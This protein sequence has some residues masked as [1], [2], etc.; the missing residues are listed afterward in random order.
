MADYGV[1]FAEQRVARSRDEALGAAAGLGYPVV[2]KSDAPGLEHKADVGGVRLGL[3]DAHAV[4]AAYDD[5]AARL[6][7]RVALQSLEPGPVELALG[8]VRDPL[9]GP[10]VLLA[11]GGTLVEVVS[12]R[13][14]ALP[15]LSRD[16]A[17]ALV[18]GFD[19]VS[20]LLSGVRGNP[21][22][23]R[24]AV[25]DALVAVGQLAAELGGAIDA[26]DVNPLICG[27]DGAV[28]VDA[29]VQPSA[30]KI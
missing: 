9:L 4:A 21:P 5:M 25:V 20:T 16:R 2:L 18:D 22:S 11:V 1:P 19:V 8:I 10:L 6:G 12:R 17:A 7:P 3:A 27:P 28:A 14:V 29:L 13:V 26:L 23:D 15:P 24:A 30:P